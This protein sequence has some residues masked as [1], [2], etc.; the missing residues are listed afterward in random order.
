MKKNMLLLLSFFVLTVSAVNAQAYEFKVLAQRG[1]VK[2]LSG[3]DWKQ[4]PNAMKLTKDNE[5]KLGDGSYLALI[6]ASGKTKELKSSG[7]YKVAELSKTINDKSSDFS[8]KYSK[9]VIGKMSDDGKSTNY[10]ITGSVERALLG[11]GPIKLYSPKSVKVNKTTEA[12]MK[13]TPY[14]EG[15]TYILEVMDLGEDVLY[16]VPTKKTTAVI[17]LSKVDSDEEEFLV[18]VR[19]KDV[20]SIKS[21]ACKLMVLDT[22]E[23][24]KINGELK[25]MKQE[26]DV[27]SAIDNMVLATYFEDHQLVLDAI[28]SYEKALTLEPN[29]DGYKQA[30]NNFLERVDLVEAKK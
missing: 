17:D 29:V 18:R 8:S 4:L 14:K 28:A 12:V 23:T 6:H 25:L 22:E 30:Y 27:N 16:S 10:A 1:D 7:T 9:F 24:Q 3:S 20:D 5:V 2:I 15:A 13:W 21:D 11:S 19:V 26:L